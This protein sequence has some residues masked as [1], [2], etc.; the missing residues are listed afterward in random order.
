MGFDI[1]GTVQTFSAGDSILLRTAP[2]D[3]ASERR[4][5]QYRLPLTA[6]WICCWQKPHT[7]FKH[8][9]SFCILLVVYFYGG[10]G[11]IIGSVMPHFHSANG[12]TGGKSL[13]QQGTELRYVIA[14]TIWI[15]LPQKDVGFDC[16]V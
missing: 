5:N 9:Q 8:G 1:P 2:Q 11:A 14:K 3:F 15:I 16:S 13:H 10:E 4:A 12:I 6:T 7:H